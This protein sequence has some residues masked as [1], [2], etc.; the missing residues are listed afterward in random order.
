MN[1]I[2]QQ[3]NSWVEQYDRMQRWNERLLAL[4]FA[5]ASEEEVVDTI[6]TC[7]QNI[8]YLKDWVMSAMEKTGHK[9]EVKKLL[10]EAFKSGEDIHLCL[11]RDLCNISKHQKLYSNRNQAVWIER[12]DDLYVIRTKKVE[13]PVI[14]VARYGVEWWKGTLGL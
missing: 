11:I 9:K 8:Y 14:V 1:L 4:D 5:T 12:A 13:L 6:L 10:D 2:F 3:H 7:F